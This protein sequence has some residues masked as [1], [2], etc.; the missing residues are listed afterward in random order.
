MPVQMYL[1]W[2]A[3][4]LFHGRRIALHACVKFRNRV[5]TAAVSPAFV[6]VNVKFSASANAVAS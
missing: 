4:V 3:M 5:A 2:K 1:G 6:I